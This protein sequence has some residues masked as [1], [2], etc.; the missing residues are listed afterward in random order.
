MHVMQILY[1]DFAYTM[2][3]YLKDHDPFR[4]RAGMEG[5]VYPERRR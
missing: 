5:R 4:E 2:T 1:W 3:E